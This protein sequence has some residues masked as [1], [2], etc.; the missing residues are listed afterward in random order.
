[1]RTAFPAFEIT[2]KMTNVLANALCAEAMTVAMGPAVNFVAPHAAA[3][4]KVFVASGA[5]SLREI[6]PTSGT[7]SSAFVAGAFKR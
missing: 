6:S 4:T 5:H 1:M 7:E 3:I 2:F